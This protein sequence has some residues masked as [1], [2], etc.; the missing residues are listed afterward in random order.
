MSDLQKIDY[1]G[2]VNNALKGDAEAYELLFNESIGKCRAICMK[3][4]D[5]ATAAGRR[6]A[7]EAVREIYVNLYDRLKSLYDPADFLILLCA[8]SRE[9]CV[10][11]A[12][13]GTVQLSSEAYIGTA[14]A[15]EEKI[16]LPTAEDARAGVRPHAQLST[17]SIGVLTLSILHALTP[18]ERLAVLRW[19]EGDPEVMKRPDTLR[20][21]FR[22]AERALRKLE[23]A[24][25]IQ[26]TDFAST[27]LSFL[28]WLLDLYDRRYE[29]STKSWYGA[30]EP[31][32]ALTL[33]GDAPPKLRN[34]V[35]FRSVWSG[36]REA[37]YLANSEAPKETRKRRRCPARTGETTPL[38]QPA[39]TAEPVRT[40]GRGLA[41][42]PAQPTMPLSLHSDGGLDPQ[43]SLDGDD[44]Y[45][46]EEPQA[47]PTDANRLGSGRA[48]SAGTDEQDSF[49]NPAPKAS[50]TKR[51]FLSTTSGKFLVCFLIA[52]AILT[53][54]VVTAGQH[55]S[56]ALV[57]PAMP[58]YS[59]VFAPTDAWLPTRVFL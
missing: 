27:P 53:V 17:E 16:L 55:T 6:K 7:D 33:T 43:P 57:R 49:T 23:P 24:V 9:V 50:A 21:A 19:H 40:A 35:S 8:V 51:G 13:D 18:E 1:T 11:L 32:Y 37:F 38:G 45:L 42:E 39:R 3:Y 48:P 46:D 31:G 34:T 58:P 10:R 30:L 41:A 25:K 36:V 28:N 59:D 2:P 14:S 26:T 4:F 56:Y 22:R 15:G 20:G 47:S 54:V 29:A 12:I 5:P 44:A 52:F